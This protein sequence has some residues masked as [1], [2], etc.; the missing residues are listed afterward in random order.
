MA[1]VPDAGSTSPKTRPNPVMTA[2]C[3]SA[4]RLRCCPGL[5]LAKWRK[6]QPLARL[7]HCSHFLVI[8]LFSPPSVCVPIHSILSYPIVPRQ[9]SIFFEQRASTVVSALIVSSLS[10]QVIREMD[11]PPP[12]P[13]NPSL[14]LS[15]VDLT[16]VDG[17]RSVRQPQPLELCP[18][19]PK[20]TSPISS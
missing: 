9:Q 16:Y 15:S 5:S 20:S 1:A 3:Q 19:P 10:G 6:K 13:M 7:L 12:V 4:A 14:S 8:S 2:T 17:C 18:N 11:K